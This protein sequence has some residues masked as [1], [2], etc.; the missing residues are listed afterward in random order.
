MLIPGTPKLIARLSTMRMPDARGKRVD[1][2]PP[3]DNESRPEHAED[4]AGGPEG[5]AVRG[6]EERPERS[7]QQGD[8]VEHD[9]AR[10]ADCRLEDPTEEEEQEHV[11]GDVA[12]ALVE[13]SRWSPAGT[14]RLR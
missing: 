5:E 10:G 4:R 11:A 12:D 13:E 7:R 6:E 3:G 9:E 14:T 1:P 2:A 8:E